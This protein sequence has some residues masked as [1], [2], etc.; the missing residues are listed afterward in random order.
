[1]YLKISAHL[2]SFEKIREVERSQRGD[3]YGYREGLSS[4]CPRF[5]II[6]SFFEGHNEQI[7]LS[8]VKDYHCAVWLKVLSQFKFIFFKKRSLEVTT[9]RLLWNC[10]GILEDCYCAQN[11][12]ISAHLKSFFEKNREF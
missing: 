8:I 10:L 1:V 4:C 12:R 9:R 3:H 2:K 7:A 11:L 6:S 5:Q